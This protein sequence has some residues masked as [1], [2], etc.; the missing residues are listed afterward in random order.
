MSGWTIDLTRALVEHLR[1]HGHLCDI[2]RPGDL[3]HDV[4]TAARRGLSGLLPAAARPIIEGALGELDRAAET[5]SVTLAVPSRRP[6]VVLSPAAVADPVAEACTTLHELVHVD[7]IHRAGPGQTVADYV[8]STELRAQREADGAGAGR[9]MRYVLTGEPPP[10]PA[11]LDDLYRLDADGQ[12]VAIGV[13]RSHHATIRA[14]GVP[15]LV[16][17]ADA[18][19]WLR[20]APGVPDDVR[21]RVGGQPSNAAA[22]EGGG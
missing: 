15:P 12:A 14:G 17:C 19:Q 3:L 7:Q 20:W 4:V 11:P 1:G 16:V 13:L 5:V 21:A 8:A 10:D 2:T 18:A 6:L 22:L 9:W